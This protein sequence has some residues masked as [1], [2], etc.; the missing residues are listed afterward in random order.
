MFLILKC[1][2]FSPQLLC[3]LLFPII[4]SFYPWHEVLLVTFSLVSS[5]STE[6]YIEIGTVAARKTVVDLYLS[7]CLSCLSQEETA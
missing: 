2:F 7:S 1:L 5:A 6:L 4:F 3:V